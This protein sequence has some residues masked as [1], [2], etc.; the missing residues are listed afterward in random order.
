MELADV[1]KM[2]ETFPV[3][4]SI[5]ANKIMELTGKGQQAQVKPKPSGKTP[6]S[7]PA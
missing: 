2:A 3:E 7:K 1:A 6:A 5:M 4:F